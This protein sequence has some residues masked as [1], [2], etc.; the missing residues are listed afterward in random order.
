MHLFI[1]KNIFDNIISQNIKY[2]YKFE[3]Y[4]YSMSI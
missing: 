1:K 3:L 4:Y 2:I